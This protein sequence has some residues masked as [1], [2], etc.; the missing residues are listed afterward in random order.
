V[1]LFALLLTTGGV[2]L[3]FFL[4][5][6]GVSYIWANTGDRGASRAERRLF[7]ANAQKQN[8]QDDV[9]P[10]ADEPALTSLGRYFQRLIAEAD[11]KVKPHQ[12]Y[13][14]A[15]AVT[16]AS[17]LVMAL[18]LRFIPW[19]ILFFTALVVGFALPVYYLKGKSAKRV[20]KFQTQFPDALDLVVRSL[21]VGHPL[22][23]A[24]ST[25]AKEIPAPLGQEFDIAAKQVTFG[26]STPEAI[27]G[28]ARRI[29]LPDVR[30]FS[31]AVQIHHESGGNLA[32]ILNGLSNVIRDRFQLFR[33]TR[34][35]TVEGRFSAW[36][37][38]L[39][40]IVMIFVMGAMQPGYYEKVGDF[41]YFQHLVVLT[42]SLLLIN[43]MAMKMITKLEV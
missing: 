8:D 16:L 21:K 9:M 2:V 37:L 14:V 22:S 6:D 39:F 30:F 26:K 42:F 3:G 4:L 34:A 27:D 25:I 28:I 38:S 35:L 24:L 23:A 7:P 13:A 29:K 41:A 1:T 17:F 36:F 15:F 20:R 18:I 31:V 5:V 32:E 11:V 33:K 43:I 40:P 12:M 19:W 10:H